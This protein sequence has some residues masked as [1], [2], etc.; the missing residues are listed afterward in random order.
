MLLLNRNLF[1]SIEA[2][3]GKENIRNPVQVV[4]LWHNKNK[5][6][7]PDKLNMFFIV[8]KKNVD[9]D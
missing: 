4:S 1:F 3:K 6:Q 9:L 2:L 7:E 8:I 5:K